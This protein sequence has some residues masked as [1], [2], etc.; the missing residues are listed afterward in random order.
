MQTSN[1]NI[2]PAAWLGIDVAKDSFDVGLHLPVEYGQPARGV[3][4]LTTLTTRL[5]RRGKP[6]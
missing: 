4:E 1:R 2:M 6:A 3:G 5:N